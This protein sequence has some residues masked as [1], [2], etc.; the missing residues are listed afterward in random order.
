MEGF[1]GKKRKNCWRVEPSFPLSPLIVLF[2]D[3]RCLDLD[4]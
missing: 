4:D 3:I 2:V 1:A